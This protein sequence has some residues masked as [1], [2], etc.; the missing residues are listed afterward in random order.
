MSW[1]PRS[2]R[3]NPIAAA[4]SDGHG[5]PMSFRSAE[6]ARQAVLTATQ[7]LLDPLAAVAARAARG[8]ARGRFE[9]RLASELESHWRAAVVRARRIGGGAGLPE[10]LE[11]RVS[12]T[13]RRIGGRDPAVARTAAMLGVALVETWR[14]SVTAHLQDNP[15][16]A[17][18]LALLRR[19]AGTAA[20]E[21][22][23][24]D[25]LLAYGATL[26]AALVTP[27]MLAWLQIGDGELLAVEEDGRVW[28]P[29]PADERLF[30]DETTSLCLPEAWRDLRV[31]LKALPP[32]PPALLLLTTDGYPNSFREEAGFL[33]VGTDLLDLLRSEGWREVARA[34]PG[35]LRE[36][37]RVGSGDDASLVVMCR[38]DIAP[39]D[40]EE[41]SC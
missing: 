19:T 2:G 7:F 32:R 25:G 9:E 22:V 38:P 29:V 14:K 18:E 37:S 34:L 4:V 17:P 3:G 8:D 40:E 41:A 27:Q 26:I 31:G 39:D 10:D 30:A 33:Q 11:H 21:R 6:G 15:F 16:R 20:C 36:A 23:R 13:A 28:R 12:E 24:R 1:L 5:N 35:W